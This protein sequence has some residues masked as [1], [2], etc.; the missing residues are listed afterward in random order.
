MWMRNSIW[1]N[2]RSHSAGFIQNTK[3]LK[4][5]LLLAGL[6]S[7]ASVAFA[8]ATT[9][10]QPAFGSDMKGQFFDV[11]WD[12]PM[13]TVSG[14]TEWSRDI[15]HVYGLTTIIEIFVF[16]AVSIPLCYTLYRFR[17]RPGDDTPPKQF[18]GNATLEIIWTTIPVFL[19]LFIAVPTWRVLFKHSTIP[20]EALKIEVIGHQWWWEFRYPDHGKIVTANELHVPENTPL[21]ITLWSEDVIHS[22]WIPKW[23]GKKDALPGHRNEFV[24]TSPSV[25]QANRRGG[26]MYQGQCVELCGS[27]HALMRFN[28]V[29]HT[30][31][32]FDAWTKTA[33]TAPNIETASQ[34]SGEEVFARCQAC[35]TIAGTPS[36]Q[37]PGNKIG[38]NLTNFG[39]RKYLAAGTRVNTPE[40]LAAWLRDPGSIKPGSLMPSLGLTEEEI[41]HV[42][43]YVRQATVKNY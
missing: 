20:A 41:A 3:L 1:W 10:Q 19:L 12:A 35:H 4:N 21:H 40:N 13:N 37:I 7:G 9:Q 8:D 27:S 36:E 43:S 39:N 33:Y 29:V 18:H 5:S 2:F 42:S 11:N 22:F 23:G 26:E 32:E 28:A 16:F 30:K 31:T 34:K 17:R 15:N 14:I 25:E 6:L 38:P 24:L